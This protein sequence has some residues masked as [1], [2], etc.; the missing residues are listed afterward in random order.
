MGLVLFSY[1]EWQKTKLLAYYARLAPN[2]AIAQG[3]PQPQFGVL[4]TQAGPAM[5]V[6]A[7]PPVYAGA[8]QG[9]TLA[10]SVLPPN[11]GRIATGWNSLGNLPMLDPLA[12]P[13]NKATATSWNPSATYAPPVGA[14]ENQNGGV[15]PAI[16]A[17]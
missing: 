5:P 10:A 1:V 9:G 15:C 16:I 12:I 17:Y 7:M 3:F 11:S 8:P 2:S 13:A 14:S 6:Y 4:Q